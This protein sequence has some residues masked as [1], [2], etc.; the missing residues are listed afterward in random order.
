MTDKKPD[1]EAMARMRERIATFYGE[2][3]ARRTEM[4]IEAVTVFGSEEAALSE[5]KPYDTPPIPA[6]NTV[7][8]NILLYIS[9]VRAKMKPAEFIRRVLGFQRGT[10]EYENAEKKIQLGKKAAK[11]DKR[12]AI[13]VPIK[14][15]DGRTIMLIRIT[16]APR[17]LGQKARKNV[18]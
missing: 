18:E 13:E 9:M 17:K 4:L 6:Q 8:E 12:E 11:N 14:L 16:E 3:A 10:A 5:F 7:N 15:P 1:P 2:I